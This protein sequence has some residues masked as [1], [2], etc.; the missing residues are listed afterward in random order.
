MSHYVYFITNVTNIFSYPS[1]EIERKIVFPCGEITRRRKQG[2]FHEDRLQ[3]LVW[4]P[5]LGGHLQSLG[6]DGKIIIIWTIKIKL[7]D[8]DKSCMALNT[9]QVSCE[10]S[11]KPSAAL[12]PNC[13]TIS[14]SKKNVPVNLATHW[15]RIQTWYFYTRSVRYNLCVNKYR[16]INGAKPWPYIQ[17]TWRKKYF[18]LMY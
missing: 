15:C 1:F 18:Q 14:I 12:L 11:N 5:T 2:D 13:A 4:N 17:Q 3:S 8:E 7:H 10:N 16:N 6:L 9:D